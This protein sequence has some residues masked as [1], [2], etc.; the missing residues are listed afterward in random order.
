LVPSLKVARTKS[1]WFSMPQ[2]PPRK[3]P[4]SSCDWKFAAAEIRVAL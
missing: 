3:A 4:T 2:M 1:N